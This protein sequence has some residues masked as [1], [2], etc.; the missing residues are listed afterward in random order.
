M[1]RQFD[2]AMEE[3]AEAEQHEA[4]AADLGLD[5]DYLA[6]F[7]YDLEPHESD[8]GVLYGYNVTFP[9]D[10]PEELAGRLQGNYGA[11]WLRVGPL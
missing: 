9:A 2:E 6:Q 5:P 4:L 1:S 11:R 3:R 7:E 8:E 10:A